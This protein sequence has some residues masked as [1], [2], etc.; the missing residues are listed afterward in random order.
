MLFRKKETL[1]RLNLEAPKRTPEAPTVDAPQAERVSVPDGRRDI[2]CEM[3]PF[4]RKADLVR[5]RSMAG[6][7][8]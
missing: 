2:N 1:Q 6:S 7:L 3:G 8:P 5:H 4:H